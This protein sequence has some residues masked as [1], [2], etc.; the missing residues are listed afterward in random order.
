MLRGGPGTDAMALLGWPA[1]GQAR[2]AWSE[3]SLYRLRSW[4]GFAAY[5]VSFLVIGV[6]WINHHALFHSVRRVDRT[7]LVLNLLL[8]LCVTTIPFS[9]RSL[10]T[11]LLVGGSDARLAAVTYGLII[12]GVALTFTA[13]CAWAW[14][15]RLL[16]PDVTVVD[17]RRE[18]GRFALGSIVIL[19]AVALPW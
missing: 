16:R 11:Y 3:G 15:A 4:P 12:E 18:I 19:A 17:A 2:Q 10:A 1:D 13:I 14:R 6:I 9:T 8:L 5:F 7:M